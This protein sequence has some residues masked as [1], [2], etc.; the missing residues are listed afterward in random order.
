MKKLLLF[1]SPILFLSS[2]CKQDCDCVTPL[3]PQGVMSINFKPNYNTKPF[4]INQIYNIDGKN[5]RFT[6]LSFLITETCPKASSTEGSCGTNAYLIDLTT[7]D[8]S[9]KSAKGFTQTLTNIFEGNKTG[10]QISLGVAPNLNASQPKDFA[11]SNPLSDGGLYW[12]DW[13]SYIFTKIEGLMDKDG[14]G[15]FETGITLH[16]G[17]DDS[18]RQTWF[19]QTFTVDTKGAT[20]LN[21]DLNI[22]TLLRGID[23]STVNSTHQTGDKPTMLKIMDNLKDGITLK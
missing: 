10:L 1:L 21:F 5:V 23:L 20:T 7:L 4:V 16:T 9:T 17:G 2:K 18:F 6:R 22:N 19:P 15:T 12:A 13:K 11:S 8:D 3:T 14:N